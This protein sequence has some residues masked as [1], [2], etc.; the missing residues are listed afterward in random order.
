MRRII[1]ISLF[2]LGFSL[3]FGQG[4]KIGVYVE[5]MV[6]W[7]SAE[8][9]TA[10]GEGSK[11]GIDGGLMLDNYFQRNYAFQTGIGIGTFGGKIQYDEAKAIT[12]YD[13]TDTLP[14]GSIMNYKVNYITVPVGLKLKTKE[15]GHFSYFARLGFTNQVNIKV[16]ATS[17]DGMLNKSVVEGEL[18]FYNLSYYVGA[19]IQ[20]HINRDSALNFAITYTNG[21]INLS[22]QDLLKIYS[23]AVSLR[24]GIIF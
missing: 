10:H 3:S 12:S 18:F 9:R 23:R 4:L 19:G 13:E 17:S 5:P 11:I 1:L 20:Y 8:S 21:F 7:F 6:S 22:R 15:I 16:K 14:A 24:V 2:L